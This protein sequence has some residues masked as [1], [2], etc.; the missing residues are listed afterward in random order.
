M[1]E[2]LP[3]ETVV[4]LTSLNDG[5]ALELFDEELKKVLDNIADPNVKAKAAREITLKVSFVPNE[6]RNQAVVSIDVKSKLV[7]HKG[8]MTQV[9][10]GEI[11]GRRVAVESNPTPGLFDKRDGKL[12]AV[13]LR[14]EKE[15]QNVR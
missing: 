10:F 2:M 15:N 6:E 4:S 13:P 7:G 12:K 14:T 5:A 9:F 11:Q 8:T 3:N 1:T